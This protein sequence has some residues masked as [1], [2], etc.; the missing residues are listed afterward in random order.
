[1]ARRKIDLDLLAEQLARPAPETATESWSAWSMQ[2]SATSTNAPA[3]ASRPPLGVVG[4]APPLSA[5]EEFRAWLEQRLYHDRGDVVQGFG[6][7]WHLAAGE[8]P[9]SVIAQH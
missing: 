9:A 3:G 5:E 6:G 7:G 8:V 2:R 4:E 1:M